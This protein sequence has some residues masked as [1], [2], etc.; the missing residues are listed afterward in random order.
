MSEDGE[1]KP[2]GLGSGFPASI[3]VRLSIQKKRH[4]QKVPPVK[5]QRF[6]N[7]ELILNRDPFVSAPGFK[8]DH[9]EEKDDRHG[10]RDKGIGTQGLPVSDDT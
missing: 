3:S 9:Q 7:K 8:I 10:C 4:P 6:W 2:C 1:E 5:K